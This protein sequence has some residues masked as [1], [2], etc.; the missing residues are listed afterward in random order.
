VTP[1]T[2]LGH[3]RLSPGFFQHGKIVANSLPLNPHAR[4]IGP[5]HEKFPQARTENRDAGIGARRE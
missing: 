3:A 2:G 5:A 4:D 1:L